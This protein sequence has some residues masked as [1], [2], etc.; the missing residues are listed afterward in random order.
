MSVRGLRIDCEDLISRVV[1]GANHDDL[2]VTLGDGV[3]MWHG[4]GAHEPNHVV[5][6]THMQLVWTIPQVSVKGVLTA[7]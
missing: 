4:S 6:D 7:S 1:W 5:P 2:N 3:R